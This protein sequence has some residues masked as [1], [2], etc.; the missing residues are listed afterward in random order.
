MGLLGPEECFA[1]FPDLELYLHFSIILISVCFFSPSCFAV[2]TIS[3]LSIMAAWDSYPHLWVLIFN[4]VHQF[5]HSF[6]PFLIHSFTYP[7]ICLSF[8]FTNISCVSPW[9]QAL[10]VESVAMNQ[11]RPYHSRANSVLED[12][13]HV[14]KSQ[15]T[16]EDKMRIT[17]ERWLNCQ[18]DRALMETLQWCWSIP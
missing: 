12:L 18:G 15:S 11:T 1:Q 14:Y 17:I 5:I 3:S 8:Y 13:R 2:N 16:R 6:L 9:G 7:F 10:F 4:S